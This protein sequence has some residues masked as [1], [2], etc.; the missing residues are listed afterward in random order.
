MEDFM[1]N[2]DKYDEEV[3]NVD[4]KE[5]ARIGAKNTR[6][7]KAI[8]FAAKL[9][10]FHL[11]ALLLYI[12]TFSTAADAEVAHGTG[13]EGRVLFTFSL[14]A[15]AFFAL[16]ISFELSSKGELR[17]EFTDL[18]KKEQFSVKLALE[19]SRDELCYYSAVYFAFQIP[20]A[21]FHHIFG[22]EYRYPTVIDNF[23]TMDAGL[24]ELTG[25]GFLG[26]LLNTLLFTFLMMLFRYLTYLRWKNEIL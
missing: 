26:A 1:K 5:V 14:I 20:F 10:I 23:F 18:M 15:I 12:F 24:M 11:V 6:K 21:I 9:F 16:F 2:I 8:L 22:F 17:R 13:L 25:I 19:L 7:R 4:P 3:K